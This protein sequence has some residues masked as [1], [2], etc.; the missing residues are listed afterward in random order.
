MRLSGYFSLEFS[1]LSSATFC[2]LLCCRFLTAC[3]CGAC[4]FPLVVTTQ[5]ILNYFIKFWMILIISYKQRIALLAMR[6]QICNLEHC[7]LFCRKTTTTTAATRTTTT[8][9]NYKKQT[10]SG[11]ISPTVIVCLKQFKRRNLNQSF[12]LPL[13]HAFSTCSI[14]YCLSGI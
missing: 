5:S 10:S 13:S 9:K 8:I 4:I 3:V 2:K 11:T 14:W 12:A 6:L 1:K 7:I